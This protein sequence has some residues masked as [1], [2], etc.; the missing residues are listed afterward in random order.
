MT[1]TSGTGA[2]PEPGAEPIAF[3]FDFSSGYAYF[4]AQDIEALAARV[5]RKVLWRPYMLGTAFKVTGVRGLSSTPL[6]RDYARRDWGRIARAKGA[7]FTLRP[8]HPLTA[9]PATRAFYAI[10]ARDPA[11]AVAFAQAV[12]AGYFGSGLDTASPDAVVA[13]AAGLG[14][15]PEALRAAMDTPAVKARARDLS[16]EAVAA[17]IF[18]S[19]FFVVDGEPFWGWDRMEMMERWI[20]SGGW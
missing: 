11:A 1:D 8:D 18:G 6:K 3:W 15:D 20:T 13:L 4:A 10:E 5:G 12:F 14:H 7:P 9:L 17:G 2:G 19:P 16:E